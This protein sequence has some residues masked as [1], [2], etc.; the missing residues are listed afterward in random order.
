MGEQATCCERMATELSRVCPE[1]SDRFACP[2]ALVHRFGDGR[3]GLIVHD[4]GKSS[5]LIAFC[6]WCGARLA[7]LDV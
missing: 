5:V 1:H 7:A 4:G 3:I 6:P 2:D